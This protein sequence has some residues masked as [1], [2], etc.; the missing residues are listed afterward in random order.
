MLN[1]TDA[2]EQEQL[3]GGSSR[4]DTLLLDIVYRHTQ[5]EASGLSH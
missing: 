4:S 5:D 2:M 3:R 1:I